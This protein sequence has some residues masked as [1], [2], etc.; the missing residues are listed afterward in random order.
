MGALDNLLCIST[1][2]SNQ[3]SD[4][5]QNGCLSFAHLFLFL[6]LLNGNPG[7]IQRPAAQAP[8]HVCTTRIPLEVR[9]G[10]AREPE[11]LEEN[12][13]CAKWGARIAR[14]QTGDDDTRPPRRPFSH[15]AFP[16]GRSV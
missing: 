12:M 5:H 14:G 3:K 1:S 7:G 16:T 9:T 2:D 13:I 8:G 11:V 15:R 10:Y 6:I 4:F